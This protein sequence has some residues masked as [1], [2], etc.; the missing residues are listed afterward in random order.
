MLEEQDLSE[1]FQIVAEVCEIETAR[2]LIK[3]TWWKNG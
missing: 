1:H 3:R 2:P